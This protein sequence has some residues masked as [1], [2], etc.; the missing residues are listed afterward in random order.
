MKHLFSFLE[1]KTTS[2]I[3]HVVVSQRIFLRFS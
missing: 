3:E 2:K 1:L